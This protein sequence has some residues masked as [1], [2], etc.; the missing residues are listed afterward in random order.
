MTRSVYPLGGRPKR[1]NRA[2]SLPSA[3]YLEST[4]A[5]IASWQ[6]WAAKQKELA[7]LGRQRFLNRY[8]WPSIWETQEVQE[9]LF[10]MWEDS[11]LLVDDEETVMDHV[12]A[13]D[14]MPDHDLRKPR[15]TVQQ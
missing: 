2:P 9:R 10:A 8:E 6:Q 3:C 13:E 1:P 5:D 7:L 4:P 12:N 11:S 14:H 15:A